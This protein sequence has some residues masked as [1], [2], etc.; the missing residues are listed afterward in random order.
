[1][2]DALQHTVSPALAAKI[3]AAIAIYQQE[4]PG[5]Q[6]YLSPFGYLNEGYKWISP[7]SIVV[8][9]FNQPLGG[10]RLTIKFNQ[11][12]GDV[13]FDPSCLSQYHLE[14]VEV[15]F[16]GDGMEV[17]PDKH[18]GTYLYIEELDWKSLTA[19]DT[20]PHAERFERIAQQVSSLFQD[21]KLHSG[22][23][24]D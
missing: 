22:I 7:D 2:A 12:G 21:I 4:F 19:L 16:W 17:N 10:A 20:H 3:S 14:A 11:L 18:S 9:E 23:V 5:A 1:M 24:R 13:H 15:E 8:I 6:A